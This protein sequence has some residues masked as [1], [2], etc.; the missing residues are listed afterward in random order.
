[1]SERTLIKSFEH[2]EKIINIYESPDGEIDMEEIDKP[3]VKPIFDSFPSES[4][5]NQAAFVVMVEEVLGITEGQE[6]ETY[7]QFFDEADFNRGSIII[8]SKEHP[9]KTQS[10]LFQHIK[11]SLTALCKQPPL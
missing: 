8:I 10:A 11:S 4:Q 1:M 5:I 7:S 3:K 2:K 6:I 9:Y